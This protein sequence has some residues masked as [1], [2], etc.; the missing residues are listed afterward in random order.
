M[1]WVEDVLP[2]ETNIVV[3]MLKDHQRVQEFV[4]KTT[5][6]RIRKAPSYNQKITLTLGKQHAGQKI[7]YWA[8]NPKSTPESNLK[9]Q[10][11]CV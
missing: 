1:E 5:D 4:S 10:D 6:F 9:I 11:G 7:L 3:C 2:V 8:A